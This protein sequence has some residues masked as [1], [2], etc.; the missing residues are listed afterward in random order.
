MVRL[1]AGRDD[2]AAVAE[3]LRGVLAR[4]G[5]PYG[6]DHQAKQFDHGYRKALEF[7]LGDG[8]GEGELAALE[9]YLD[10]SGAALGG[11]SRNIQAADDPT[12]RRPG[13]QNPR[14]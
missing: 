10:G 7:L 3:E 5:M 8:N 1:H 12:P 4:V 9:K 6:N 11:T 13:V 14:I 2:L